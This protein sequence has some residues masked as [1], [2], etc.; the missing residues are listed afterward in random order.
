MTVFYRGHRYSVIGTCKSVGNGSKEYL[1]KSGER[2]I[3]VLASHC[4]ELPCS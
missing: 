2:L 4:A 3:V 1:L